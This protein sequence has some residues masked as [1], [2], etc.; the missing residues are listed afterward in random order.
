MS[1]V[2]L[3][4]NGR[5]LSQWTSV[6]VTRSLTSIADSFDL[7]YVDTDRAPYPIDAGDQCVVYVGANRVIT[8]HVDVVRFSYAAAPRGGSSQHVFSVQGRS[9]TGDLFDSSTVPDPA[10]FQKKTFLQIAT[11]ICKPFGIPVTLSGNVD[12]LVNTPID[13]HSVEVGESVGDTLGRLAQKLG[14]LLTPTTEGLLQIGRP[15]RIDA[16]SGLLLGPGGRVKSAERVSDY[17]DRHSL[18]IAFGQRQGSA[19]LKGN[20]AREGRGEA[21]DRRVTRYRPL[22]WVQDGSSDTGNL[23]RATEWRRNT[24]AGQSQ[25]VSYLVQGWEHSPGQPW[26]PG[27]T[28]FVEDPLLR[29]ARIGLIVEQCEFSFGAD[30]GS[31]TR[32]DLVLPESLQGVTPPSEPKITDGVM[33]W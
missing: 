26:A 25:R 7:G 33:T 28:V 17:R 13:R 21:T 10:Q 19:L 23:V 8:G 14:V 18:Y 20:A 27:L 1:S 30:T 15:P 31:E 11:Q 16:G 32:L 22:V 2:S 12:E 3:A 9:K 24:R 29:L 5:R 6:R 4:V